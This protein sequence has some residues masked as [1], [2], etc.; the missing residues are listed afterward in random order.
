MNE[1]PLIK[2]R[3]PVG[4]TVAFFSEIIRFIVI[5]MLILYIIIDALA[6][7][8]FT[9][10]LSRG[11]TDSIASYVI[12]FGG[13]VAIFAALEAYY[14]KGSSV[15]M[16]F[17]IMSIAMLCAWFWFIL[18]SRSIH[19]NVSEWNV[20]INITGIVTMMLFAV[21]LKS[22]IPIAQ[23]YAR[24][25]SLKGGA[26]KAAAVA[27]APIDTGVAKQ[28]IAPESQKRLTRR[29]QEEPPPPEDF[30]VSCPSCKTKIPASA[31]VCPHC[32]VWIR[33]KKDF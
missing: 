27:A 22:L 9:L 24:R 28:P 17:G 18:S 7:S 15:R 32:K 16:L 19:F 4:A 30:L 29:V 13:L 1:G 23:Y 20:T 10:L 6:Q 12:L 3:H 8:N 26:A 14:P 25:D 5:P 21:A 33:Q 11:E 2:K 31:D